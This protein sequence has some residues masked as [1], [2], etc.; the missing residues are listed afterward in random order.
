MSPALDQRHR[1]IALPL[2]VAGIAP[3]QV[4]VDL[5]SL[6]GSGKRARGVANR[7]Q[8]FGDFIEGR[9]FAVLEYIGGAAAPAR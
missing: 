1:Q 6:L 5:P 3:K 7:Q 4:R 9:S 2:G 8:R